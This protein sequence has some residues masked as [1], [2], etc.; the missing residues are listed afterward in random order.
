MARLP[1]AIEQLSAPRER[2]L[3]YV[4]A[5]WATHRLVVPAHESLHEQLPG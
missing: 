4:G 3:M 5:T 1:R 2:S